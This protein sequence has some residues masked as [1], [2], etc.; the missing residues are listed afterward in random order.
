MI[1]AVPTSPWHQ[2]PISHL[3][4]LPPVVQHDLLLYQPLPLGVQVQRPLVAQRHLRHGVSRG[5]CTSGPTL[6]NTL[7]CDFLWAFLPSSSSLL[8]L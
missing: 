7:F 6:A 4:G 2:H 3:A 1:Y 5:N 8:G